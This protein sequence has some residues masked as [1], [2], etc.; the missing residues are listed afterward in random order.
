M[1]R[2]GSKANEWT[3]GNR[4]YREGNP[5]VALE[6]AY[7]CRDGEARSL[8]RNLIEEDAFT[9]LVDRLRRIGNLKGEER[10]RSA[11]GTGSQFGR[12]A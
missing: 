4:V 10:A 9:A 6:A 5:M 3:S 7:A 11:R 12:A 8:W 2:R 1:G